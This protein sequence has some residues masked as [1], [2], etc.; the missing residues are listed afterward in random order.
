MLPIPGAEKSMEAMYDTNI[1]N[2][3]YVLNVVLNEH[4]KYGCFFG[5]FEII[6]RRNFIC[7]Y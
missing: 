3:Q 1:Q 7:I 2:I 5:I 6:I 4:E